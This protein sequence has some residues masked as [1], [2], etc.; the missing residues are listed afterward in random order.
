MIRSRIIHQFGL[1]GLAVVQASKVVTATPVATVVSGNG[2]RKLSSTSI[3]VHNEEDIAAFTDGQISRGIAQEN[4]MNPQRKVKLS[5]TSKV[6]NSVEQTTPN[7]PT[8]IM[9]SPSELAYTGNA[10]MPITSELRIVTPDE[11]VPPG[12][13]PIFRIMVSVFLMTAPLPPN[14]ERRT[15]H[16]VEV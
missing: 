4:S 11:D 2:S 15:C 7:E 14:K 16:P 10:I 1:R 13:W 8:K 6:V 9:S 3:L 12:V 5:E